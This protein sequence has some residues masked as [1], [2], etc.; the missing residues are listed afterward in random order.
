[1][2]NALNSALAGLN[3]ATDQLG[4]AA[5]NIANALSTGENPGDAYRAME[6]SQTSK[7]GAP[8]VLVQEKE[9]PTLEL[10]APEHSAANDNG[11][12]EFPNVNLGEEVVNLLQA[13]LAY[14]ANL[15]VL[16]TVDE[17]GDALFEI[18]A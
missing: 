2:I 1:M 7:Y 17:M 6:A 18:F 12:V 15:L 9:Q 5:S 8:Y 10:Y 13:E 14:K 4:V 16:K 11:M 3:A